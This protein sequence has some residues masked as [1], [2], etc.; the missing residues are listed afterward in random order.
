MRNKQWSQH[1]IPMMTGCSWPSFAV[2][3]AAAV[4][5]WIETCKHG[6]T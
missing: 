2:P 5:A 4:C 1:T 3:P 6:V